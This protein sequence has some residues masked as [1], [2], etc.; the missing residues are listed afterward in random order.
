MLAT[1]RVPPPPGASRPDPHSVGLGTP[2]LMR[3][4]FASPVPPTP[5]GPLQLLSACCFIAEEKYLS[6]YRAPVLLAVGMEGFWGLVL[7]AAALPALARVNGP[8]GLPLDSLADA[9]AVGEGGSGGGAP[10]RGTACVCV[11]VQARTAP[12]AS[13]PA[14]SR[15][16][17]LPTPTIVP[18]CCFPARAERQEVRRSPTLQWTT[19]VTVISIA[20]FNFF[21]VSVTK[22]LSGAARA[23]IDACRTLFIWLFALRMGWER[24]H[25]L[26]VRRG[27]GR[28][29]WGER[30]LR[31]GWMRGD[32]Q[33][34]E[35]GAL[36]SAAGG[37]QST[38][39]RRSKLCAHA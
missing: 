30:S 39:T 22:R 31:G 6:R 34:L 16:P 15:S 29:A 4:L 9:L 20:F 14:C 17:C 11:C 3:M 23:T 25:M 35:E 2:L 28:R 19:A 27:G 10:R 26:Q 1:A 8:D 36:S 12:A 32:A 24:F 18:A 37:A 38:E 13:R 5:T 33:G 7:C 21:G